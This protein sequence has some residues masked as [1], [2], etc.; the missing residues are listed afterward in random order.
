MPYSTD[1]VATARDLVR[2]TRGRP[3]QA[4]L[5]RAVSTAY[6]ALFHCLAACCADTLV[7]G[8]GADRDAAAWRQ[9]YRALQH[10]QTRK[11][12]ETAIRRNFP[13]EV[14]QFATLFVDMQI[15][16]EA[17]DYDPYMRFSKSD[18]VQSID[19]AEDAIT[20][21]AKAPAS[22]RRAFAVYALLPLR[23]S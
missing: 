14:A 8:K 12:F 22:D 23:T 4:N 6:Y 20:Q 16:R 5:R 2:T 9:A 1:L 3:R 18:V 17:A 13:A 19:S 11:R 15:Q 10:G 21:F 7:G